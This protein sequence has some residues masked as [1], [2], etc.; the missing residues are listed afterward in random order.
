MKSVL[1]IMDDVVVIGDT[2]TS[3]I[4][5]VRRIDCNFEP[6][7]G[8]KV[9]VFSNEQKTFVSKIESEAAPAIAS[10]PNERININI[11]NDNSH[12]N[13]FVPV[14]FEGGKNVVN[15][16][17]YLLI[18][19]FLGGLGVHKFYTGKIGLG[20]VYLLFC[21][22]YIPSI[23]AFIEFIIACCKPAD[24]HGRIVI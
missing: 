9:H 17:T 23:I 16:T 2:Q 11:V 18:T 13:D 12:K 3:A 15:K 8:D 6:T 19:F 10:N 14:A 24:A 22:T 4:L 21:W 5:E 20:I 7:I 1:Q